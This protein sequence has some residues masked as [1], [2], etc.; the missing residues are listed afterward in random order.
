MYVRLRK[1]AGANTDSSGIVVVSILQALSEPAYSAEY[2]QM[3]RKLL[4]RKAQRGAER[5]ALR[6]FLVNR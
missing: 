6:K 3:C 5:V 1:K 4:L 2:A